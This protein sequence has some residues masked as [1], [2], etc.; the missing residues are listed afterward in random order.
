MNNPARAACPQ[1]PDFRRPGQSSIHPADRIATPT[2]PNRSLYVLCIDDDAVILEV[3][4][5][6]LMY[7]AHRVRVATGGQCGIEL[8][9][10][11]ILNREPYDVVITDMRM[12]DLD[13]FQ[14]ARMIKAKSPHTPVIMMTGEDKSGENRDQTPAVDVVIGKPARMQELNE[15]LLRITEYHAN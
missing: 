9:C 2:T 7:F 8:F 15:L 10:S 1:A 13:G 6:C 14:V 3:T 11:A 4:K 5:D 12:P